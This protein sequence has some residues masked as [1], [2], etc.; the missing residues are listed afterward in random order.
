M[1]S[2]TWGLVPTWSKDPKIARNS[3]N[4]RSETLSEKPAFRDAF[5]EGRCIVP[6]QAWWEWDRHGRKT[7]INPAEG[8]SFLVA[9]LEANGTFTIVTQESGA[10]LRELHHRQPVLLSPQAA[11]LWALTDSTPQEIREVLQAR[12]PQPISL[13]IEPPKIGE[14][15][16][17]LI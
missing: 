6:V 2:A 13:E 4:A 10:E 5:Q 17:L 7:R 8:Q 14:Q 3:I 9:G 16:G 11:R 12:C 1:R 15:L